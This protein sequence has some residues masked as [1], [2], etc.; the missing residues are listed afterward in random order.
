[1]LLWLLMLLIAFLQLERL[2]S[3]EVHHYKGVEE[4]IDAPIRAIW[5]PKQPVSH[6][7]S[8]QS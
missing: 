6:P 5:I 8:S 4:L 3:S 1:M 7:G 2:T